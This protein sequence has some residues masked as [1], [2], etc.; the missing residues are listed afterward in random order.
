MAEFNGSKTRAR[1]EKLYRTQQLTQHLVAAALIRNGYEVTFTSGN[2]P[3]A[4]LMVC[5]RDGSHPFLVDV[6][7]QSGRNAWM[8]KRR[9]TN[10]NLFYICVVY[11]KTCSDDIFFVLSHEQE[12]KVDAE[13]LE[14]MEEKGTS[15]I[16]NERKPDC[17]SCKCHPVRQANTKPVRML[18]A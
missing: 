10:L 11:G 15:D 2:S 8:I 5:K 7:D 17:V 18:P 13:E 12:L 1:A 4:D 16:G 14:R 3:L 9:P 6:K